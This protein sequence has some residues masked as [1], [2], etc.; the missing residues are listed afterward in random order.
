MS[1]FDPIA[2]FVS[3][4]RRKSERG[5]RNKFLWFRPPPPSHSLG[6]SSWSAQKSWG[7]SKL[8]EFSSKVNKYHIMLKECQEFG[9][10][11]IT[12]CE[13]SPLLLWSGSPTFA[14]SVSEEIERGQMRGFVPV[15]L[16]M[17][18]LWIPQHWAR[19]LRQSSYFVLSF[20]RTSKQRLILP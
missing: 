5:E 13:S 11:L 16:P 20:F 6:P 8:V 7:N 15:L 2:H 14:G 9:S 10:W 18:L 3:Q 12:V 19:Y 17:L 4:R 1:Q